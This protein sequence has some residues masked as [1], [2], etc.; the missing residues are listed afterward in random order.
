[1]ELKK[2][3]YGTI[4]IEVSETLSDLS[5]LCLSKFSLDQALQYQNSSMETKKKISSNRMDYVKDFVQIG[6][7]RRLMKNYDL[8]RKELEEAK[9]IL[10]INAKLNDIYAN[11]I[12]QLGKKILK[13]KECYILKQMNF[14]F[15]IQH[16]K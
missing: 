13:N 5:S 10:E 2:D 9:K 7:I 16:L 3:M 1:L 6:T 8:S 11:C 4:S 15:H 14:N 12:F